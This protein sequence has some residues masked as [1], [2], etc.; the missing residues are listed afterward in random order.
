MSETRHPL[1][2]SL[3]VIA[4][5]AALLRELRERVRPVEAELSEGGQ[6]TLARV[7]A[8]LAEGEG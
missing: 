8:A 2:D 3:P 1:E 4:H 6:E 7:D 5:A